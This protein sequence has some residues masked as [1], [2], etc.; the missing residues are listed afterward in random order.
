MLEARGLACLRGERVIFA[1]VSFRL[2]AGGTLLLVGATAGLLNYVVTRR[3][4]R[5]LAK[6]AT[7]A[8]AS[9]QPKF[10]EVPQS[11]LK[12]LVLAM[13]D[14]FGAAEPVLDGEH[15]GVCADEEGEVIVLFS[16]DA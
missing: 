3:K 9:G 5:E 7:A 14:A 13:N 10:I 8:I 1:E 11:A 2:D 16:G 6:E 12:P 15:E 4:S